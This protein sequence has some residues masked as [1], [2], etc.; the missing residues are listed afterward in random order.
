MEHDILVLL[1]DFTWPECLLLL[2]LVTVLAL[3]DYLIQ[4]VLI[5]SALLRLHMHRYQFLKHS[6]VLVQLLNPLP[7]L[8]LRLNN[9]FLQLIQLLSIDFLGLFNEVQ[10]LLPIL[11]FMILVNFPDH[12]SHF[13]LYGIVH[14]A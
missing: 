14:L 9:G 12:F 2:L 11:L 6:S 5:D 7:E 8:V 3:V 13:L 10:G 1:H 4:L